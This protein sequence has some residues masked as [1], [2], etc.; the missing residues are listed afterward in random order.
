MRL[1]DLLTDLNPAQREAVLHEGGPLLVLAGAGSGKT[2]VL[3]YRVAYLVR[4]RGVPPDRILA[5]TFTNKAAGEMRERIAQLVGER[6]AER[7]WVGTFHR[8]CGRLLRRWGERI[9]LSPRFV[10]YDEEDQRA[11]I[12][13]ALRRLQLDERRVPPAAVLAAISGAKNEGVALPDYERR[14]TTY[15]EHLVVAVWRE[16][17]RVLGEHGALD[18][19]DMLLETL[20]LFE[21]CPDVLAACQERFLHILVDEYQDTNPVQFRLLSALAARH[22][23]LCVV[24]DV[25]QAI[26]GWRGADIRNILEFERDFPDARV[27]PLEQNY[28]STRTIL[29]AAEH[30]ITHNPHRYPKRLWTHNPTG[31]PLTVYAALDEHDEARFVVEE[32][33]KLQARGYPLR[34]CAV[35]YRTNAQSRQFEEAFLRTGIPYQVVGALRFYER[36]EVKDL[37]AY[38][39]LL[40]N[41]RDVLSLRRVINVPRRGIGEGTVAKIEAAA[42][43]LGIP[44]LQAMRHPEVLGSLSPQIRRAVEGFVAVLEE[45][46]EAMSR[47]TVSALI[48]LAIDRTGYRAALEAEGTEEASSRLENLRELVTVAQEFERVSGEVS[49]EA[50]LE[51][52]ALMTDV[53]TYDETQDR[54]TLMT[55]HAAKGL[56]FPVIFL[57]GLEEGLFPHSRSLEDPRQLE[58]ERRLAYVGLT[59]AKELVY[60]TYARQRTLFGRTTVNVPSRF[61]EELPQSCLREVSRATGGGWPDPQN[62]EVLQLRVGEWVQHRHFGRGRVVE[63]EGEGSRTVVTVHFPGLGTKRLAL[64]YAPLEKAAE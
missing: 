37:L 61:L 43:R 10:V 59:R 45:L 22:R 50:F 14:A 60:L 42:E 33:R 40:A 16:Y 24:G 1:S 54:V 29:E 7:I 41:P 47:C 30:L 13:E 21:T 56:E 49:V 62:Q 48:A 64:S 20:R 46:E 25:D 2:R 44:P 36:R 32:I 28:R 11:A 19:D 55:L 12:R 9:G 31:E 3:A 58:E 57:C 38:L 52:V 6:V 23:N 18:F 5:V 63:I 34:A 8:I 53:D 4:G 39:R 15:F 26:Y 17:Q 35:L 51:H 27:I